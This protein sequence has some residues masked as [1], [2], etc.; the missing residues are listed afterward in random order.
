MICLLQHILE[1]KQSKR[2]KNDIYKIKS[3]SPFMEVSSSPNAGEAKRDSEEEVEMPKDRS[4]PF[5]ET[6]FRR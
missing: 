4:C 3:D 5:I 6:T 2:N 1:L